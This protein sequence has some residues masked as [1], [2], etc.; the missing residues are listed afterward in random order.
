MGAL[1]HL[2]H[3]F[4]C[5]SGWGN[6][7]R[8]NKLK[9]FQ[10]VE[11]KMSIDCEGCERKVRRLLEGMKGV[12]SVEIEP[13]KSKVT[14][15]GHVNPTRVVARLAFRTGKKVEIWPYLPSDVVS[16]HHHDSYSSVR[17]N[18]HDPPNLHLPRAT[19]TEVRYTAAFS[20]DNTAACSIM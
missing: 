19:S 10:T 16:H 11:M 8:I 6:R 13:N 18:H 14:V 2:S 3:I 20:D 9:H 4:D 12:T 17:H 1:D 7:R 5:S 15:V